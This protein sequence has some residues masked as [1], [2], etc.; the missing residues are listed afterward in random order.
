MLK[1]ENFSGNYTDTL[2]YSISLNKIKSDPPASFSIKKCLR[3]ILLIFFG[4]CFSTLY[5]ASLDNSI[6]SLL[7]ILNDRRSTKHAEIGD[8]LRI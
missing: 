1:V 6:L 8:T 7:L 3:K 2:F 4:L 5:N